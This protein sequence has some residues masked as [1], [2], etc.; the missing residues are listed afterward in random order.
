MMIL[1]PLLKRAIEALVK[2]TR[3]MG[4]TQ[5]IQNNFYGSLT[6]QGLMPYYFQILNPG[7]A[8]AL[9]WCVWNV[10]NDF[11]KDGSGECYTREEIC[12]ECRVRPIED[13]G[14]IHF[15]EL[16]QIWFLTRSNMEIPLGR[17]GNGTGD[18]HSNQ[19]FGYCH[20]SGNEGYRNMELL[21]LLVNRSF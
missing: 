16:Q 9:N 10:I 7:R 6:F 2:K 21:T 13:I 14:L 19:F 8:L 1:K 11:I 18:Y 12:E 20:S 3:W 5:R 15:N 17:S 4:W